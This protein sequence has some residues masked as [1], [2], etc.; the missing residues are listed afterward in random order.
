MEITT[1]R[2]TKAITPY[3]AKDKIDIDIGNKIKDLGIGCK[4]KSYFMFRRCIRMMVD[5]PDETQFITK[6]IYPVVAKEFKTTP[7]AVERAIRNLTD[8]INCSED[9][10]IEIIGW[11][12]ESYTNKQIISAIA[13]GVR[14]KL[15]VE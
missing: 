3:T 6:E 12:A 15:Y 8:C 7:G 11:C 13:E 4:R 9:T 5:N 14:D 1:E 10:M 2:V